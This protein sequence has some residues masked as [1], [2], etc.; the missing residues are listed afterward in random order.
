MVKNNKKL[1]TKGTASE[2]TVIEMVRRNNK[3]KLPWDVCRVLGFEHLEV[4]GNQVG[5]ADSIDYPDISEE[6]EWKI[7]IE[8]LAKQFGGKID[9]TKK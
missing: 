8:F 9:W 5:V 7:A 3:I 4:F 1:I 2:Q 6:K